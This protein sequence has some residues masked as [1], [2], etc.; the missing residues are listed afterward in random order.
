MT[1]CFC[2]SVIVVSS[3]VSICSSVCPCPSPTEEAQIEESVSQRLLDMEEEKQHRDRELQS[4]E[5]QLRQSI[6]KSQIT[7]SELQY[8]L[9]GM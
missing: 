9:F 8:P 2:V 3:T 4:L 7:D 5:E 1:S 6:A